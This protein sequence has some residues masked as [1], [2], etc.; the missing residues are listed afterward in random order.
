MSI[1]APLPDIATRPSGRALFLGAMSQACRPRQ[2]LTVSQ[3]ADAHRVLSSKGSGEPGQWKT[4][5]TPYLREVMDC[6]SSSSPVERVV[7]IK[8]AQLGFTS[9]ALNWIGYIMDHSPG[10]ILMVVP[11][12]KLLEELVAQDLNPLLRETPALASLVSDLPRTAAN[13]KDL[14]EFPGGLLMMMGA[15]S[16][17]NY[18]QKK[19]K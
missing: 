12:E 14:R 5:R 17:D 7:V 9:A 4:S 16:A 10:P 11:S 6:L 18:R 13:R 1:T 3:W 2:R 15:N 8:A 19:V